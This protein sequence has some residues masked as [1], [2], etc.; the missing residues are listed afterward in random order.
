MYIQMSYWIY[1]EMS[2]YSQIN[3]GDKKNE[4]GANSWR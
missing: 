1:A 2:E 4:Y 3:K